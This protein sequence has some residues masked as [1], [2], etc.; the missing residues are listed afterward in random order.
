MDEEK[1]LAGG[2]V[3]RRARPGDEDG[4]LACIRALAEY[5]QEPD[6]VQTTADDLRLSLF[7]ES[8]RSSRTSLSGT[9][10]WWRSPS[11]S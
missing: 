6:A 2:A 4:I 3:L 1:A 5:E 10:S 8:P 11:G 9:G 7:A